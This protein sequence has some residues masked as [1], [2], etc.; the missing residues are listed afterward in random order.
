MA[1]NKRSSVWARLAI[2]IVIIA[3]GA[4]IDARETEKKS[5]YAPVDIKKDL[6]ATMCAGLVAFMR[7][8]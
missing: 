1:R 8:L 6:S 7:Q 2:V 5:N 4:S 3:C